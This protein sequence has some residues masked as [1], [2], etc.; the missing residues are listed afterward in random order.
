MGLGTPEN[1]LTYVTDMENIELN[2]K[3]NLDSPVEICTVI[4]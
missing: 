3:L 1:V 4:L 2:L